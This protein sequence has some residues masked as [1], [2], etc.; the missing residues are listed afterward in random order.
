MYEAEV[1][2]KCNIDETSMPTATRLRVSGVQEGDEGSRSQHHDW[3][4]QGFLKDWLD[5]KVH[6]FSWTLLLKRAEMLAEISGPTVALSICWPI[7]HHYSAN[8]SLW[9][10]IVKLILLN[11]VPRFFCKKEYVC[12][13]VVKVYITSFHRSNHYTIAHHTP[14]HN[15]DCSNLIL[16][17]HLAF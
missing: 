5:V 12:K 8:H 17:Y 3:S 9:L 13:Y 15:T 2:E 7:L 6:S 16:S 1:P 14:S 4:L 11:V 10:A